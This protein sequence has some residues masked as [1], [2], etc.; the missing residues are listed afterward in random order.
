MAEELQ[1]LLNQIQK[2]GIEKAEREA[3]AILAKAKEDAAKI[4]SHAEA[5]AKAMIEKAEAESTLFTQRSTASL[6]QAA[7]DVIITA[8]EGVGNMIA[9]IVAQAAAEELSGD[10]MKEMMLKLAES[11]DSGTEFLVN[12]EDKKRLAEFVAG[13][14]LAAA[15]RGVELKTDNDVLQGFKVSF[16]DDH[17]YMDFTQDAIAAALMALLRPNLAGIVGAAA[18]HAVK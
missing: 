7:R 16:K 5:K 13:K 3:S 10:V 2:E 4:V 12:A 8:G 18:Q 15:R 14:F 1:P 11:A 6:Q 9:G 17:A